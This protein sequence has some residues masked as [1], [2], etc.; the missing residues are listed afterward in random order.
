[1]PVGPLTASLSPECADECLKSLLLSIEDGPPQRA[2]RRRDAPTRVSVDAVVRLPG[3]EKEKGGLIFTGKVLSGF[4]QKGK[5]Y[6][7]SLGQSV[8]KGAV[9]G[10]GLTERVEVKSLEFRGGAFEKVPAGWAV[11]FTLVSVAEDTEGKV[12]E[13]QSDSTI[14]LKF[15]K[16]GSV[17]FD[18]GSVPPSF[19][20]CAGRFVAR[21]LLVNHPGEIRRGYNPLMVVHQACVGVRLEDIVAK[22]DRDTGTVVERDP[23][24]LRRGDSAVIVL[25]PVKPVFVET[26]LR[27]ARFGRFVLRDQAASVGI[28]VVLSVDGRS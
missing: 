7:V 23:A 13:A 20:V 6:S 24:F 16:P 5:R 28:G 26:F 27:S 2:A 22:L 12:S 21:V 18:P 1:M 17:V 8:S 15:V 11:G 10:D 9:C 4:L 3:T 19:F 25:V 14:L